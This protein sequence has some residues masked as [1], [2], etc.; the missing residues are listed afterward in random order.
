M[1]QNF[2]SGENSAFLYRIMKMCKITDIFRSRDSSVGIGVGYG[3]D[4]RGLIN[5]RGKKYF[6]TPQR[7]DQLLRPTQ[8]PI[9]C[10]PRDFSLGVKRPEREDDLSPPSSAR[11]RMVELYLHSPLRIYCVVLCSL[12][13]RKT[14]SF[15]RYFQ[16]FCLNEK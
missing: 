7:P 15:Y 10:V 9:Q 16:S 14:L 6:S 12:S 1:E 3:L 4:G 11:S 5:G 2:G 8:P 13:T